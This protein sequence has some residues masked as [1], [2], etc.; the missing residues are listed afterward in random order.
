MVLCLLAIDEEEEDDIALQIHFTLIQSFC[1]DNDINI[2]RVSGMQR[3]AQLLGEPVETQGTPEA[4]DLHCLL[5][6]VSWVSWVCPAL[7]WHLGLCLST[8][9]SSALSHD[10]HVLWAAPQGP[11]HPASYFELACFP[12]RG[13]GRGRPLLGLPLNPIFSPP[14]EPSHRWMEEPRPGGG[15]Q[16]L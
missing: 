12:H 1:C 10:W 16:L 9:S 14:T 15:S 4:R 13:L 6:T 3:L 2:V 7:P 11:P 8:K 5:V